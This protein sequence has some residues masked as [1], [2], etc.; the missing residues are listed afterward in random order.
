MLKSKSTLNLSQKY[1]SFEIVYNYFYPLLNVE[2]LKLKTVPE[3]TC[4]RKSFVVLFI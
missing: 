3:Y 2:F 1:L 4:Y